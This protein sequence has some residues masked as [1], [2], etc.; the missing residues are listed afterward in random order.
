M[1]RPNKSKPKT[2]EKSSA[3]KSKGA[4]PDALADK[5][6]QQRQLDEISAGKL[7]AEPGRQGPRPP[8]DT[9]A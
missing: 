3:R 2:S 1:T 4:T 5:A 8:C 7:L 9:D 6:L